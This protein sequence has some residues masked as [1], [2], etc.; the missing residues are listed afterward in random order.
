MSGTASTV[1]T[2]ATPSAPR[3]TR[4]SRR[5]STGAAPGETCSTRSSNT[6]SPATRNVPA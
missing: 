4:W 6:T 5:R 1:P 2:T 3:R